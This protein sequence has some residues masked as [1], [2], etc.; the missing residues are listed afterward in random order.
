MYRSKNDFMHLSVFVVLAFVLC[1]VSASAFDM[2]FIDEYHAN[3]E[4]TTEVATR[5]IS[6]GKVENPDPVGIVDAK[7]TLKKFYFEAYG[8][9][10]FTN[11]QKDNGVDRYDFEKYEFT[12]GYEDRFIVDYVNTLDLD[13]GYKYTSRNTKRHKRDSRNEFFVDLTTGLPFS[14]GIKLNYDPDHNYVYIAPHAS[15]DYAFSEKLMLKNTLTLYWYNH[16]MA[17]HEWGV[18]GNAFTSLYYQAYLKYQ[19]TEHVSFGPVFEASYA[20][21]ARVRE[22]ARD[23]D[24]NNEMNFLFGLRLDADF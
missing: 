21:D 11:Y 5:R 19:F 10:N 9:N 4:I 3:A 1:C 18:G 24:K 7:I 15:Y 2:I 16:K 23:S 17:K 8:V 22:A 12:F 20:L 13:V 6:K 14:P